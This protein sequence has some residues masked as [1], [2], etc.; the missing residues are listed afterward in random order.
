MGAAEFQLRSSYESRN[1]ALTCDESPS[2]TRPARMT[3]QWFVEFFR[4]AVQFW[5]LGPGDRGKVMVLV[6][7]SNLCATKVIRFC[8]GL[9]IALRELAHVIGQDIQWTVIAPGFLVQTI[10]D[11][12]RGTRRSG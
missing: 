3:R 9:H 12:T 2:H 7:I 11:C 1:D 6:V 4:D 5:Q 10:K 8:A